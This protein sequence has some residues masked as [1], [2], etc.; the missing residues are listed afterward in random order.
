MNHARIGPRIMIENLERY[1]DALGVFN[2]AAGDI[3]NPVI[4]AIKNI[5]G[6]A[7]EKA[8][9]QS[10]MSNK[11]PRNVPFLDKAIVLEAAKLFVA[12][13]N[14]PNHFT[15]RD[16]L[17]HIM[18]SRDLAGIRHARVSQSVYSHVNGFVATGAIVRIERG[19]YKLG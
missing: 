15:V 1:R 16:L 19:K 7:P 9:R 2:P 11:F 17:P 5:S 14:N 18:A 13:T 4:A 12:N 8:A 10:T 6:P 3:F